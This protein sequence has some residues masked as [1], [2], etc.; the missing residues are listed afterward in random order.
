MHTLTHTR[1]HTCNGGFKWRHC[2][3]L[4]NTFYASWPNLCE[5]RDK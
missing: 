1:T 4:L 5:L 3:T 2:E